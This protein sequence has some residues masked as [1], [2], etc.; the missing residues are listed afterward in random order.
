MRCMS[1]RTNVAGSSRCRLV[2]VAGI[3]PASFDA[4]M[5]LLRAQSISDCREAGG[6]RQPPVSVADFGVPAASSASTAGKPCFMRA[7]QLRRARIRRPTRYLNQPKLNQ[8]ASAS[9]SLETLAFVFGS[10]SLTWLRRPRLASLTSTAEVETDHPLG[11][12]VRHPLYR[13]SVTALQ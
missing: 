5:S 9:S 2:E 13:R 4:S 7:R 11:V 6:H 12:F 3:E 10:G 8:A 1:A